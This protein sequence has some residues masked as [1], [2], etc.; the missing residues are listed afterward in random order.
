MQRMNAAICGYRTLGGNERLCGDLTA[1]HARTILVGAA[2]AENVLLDLLD[3]EKLDE[4][5]EKPL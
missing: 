3:V 5:V 4:L 2:S 1:E